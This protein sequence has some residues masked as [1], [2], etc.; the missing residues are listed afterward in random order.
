MPMVLLSF[1]IVLLTDI[2]ITN[3]TT[4]TNSRP[5]TRDT[6]L[7]AFTSSKTCII[8]GLFYLKVN[9]EREKSF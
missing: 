6:C 5:I 9:V 3:V 8:L 2:E 7:G 4:H 1:A